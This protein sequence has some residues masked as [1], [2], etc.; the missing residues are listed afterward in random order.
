MY[1]IGEISE[2]AVVYDHLPKFQDIS[3]D[4]S[5]LAWNLKIKTNET[6]EAIR[7]TFDWINNYIT[8][9]N[10]IPIICGVDSATQHSTEASPDIDLAQNI[11]PLKSEIVPN[12]PRT[13]IIANDGE[14]TSTPPSA[15]KITKRIKS[16][17][18]SSIRVQVEK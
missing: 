8:T 17:P 15:A 1:D 9:L 7:E 2:L 18:S 12:A 10:I 3:V 11:Q 13:E 14:T 4:R 16:N 5:Y 6:A